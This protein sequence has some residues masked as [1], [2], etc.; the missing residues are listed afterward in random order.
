MEES[1]VKDV[2]LALFKLQVRG[3]VDHYAV[4]LRLLTTYGAIASSLGTRPTGQLAVALARI[5]EDDHGAK[6]PLRTAVVVNPATERP[7]SGWYVQAASL[8]LLRHAA[9]DGE[10]ELFWQSQ[11]SALGVRPFTLEEF[12][13]K[14]ARDVQNEYETTVVRQFKTRAEGKPFIVDD[15]EQI[16][17]ITGLDQQLRDHSQVEALPRRG[18]TFF[19]VER[20]EPGM[21]ILFHEN[22][23]IPGRRAMTRVPTPYT[24]TSVQIEESTEGGLDLVVW[25]ARQGAE[26]PRTFR[27]T[28]GS[29]VKLLPIVDQP[30]V[31]QASQLPS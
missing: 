31:E 9:T 17:D 13:E 8:G 12:F 2:K 19:P 5:N 25:Q 14:S 30:E 10:K 29:H 22:F 16:P 6:R 21:Q 18:Y 23:K 7:G 28:A 4:H 26:E 20:L 27:S 15:P 1:I 3:I 11:I 24:V